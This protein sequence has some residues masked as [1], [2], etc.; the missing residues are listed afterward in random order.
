MKSTLHFF[1]FIF[2][3]LPILNFS[4]VQIGSDINGEAEWDGFGNSI[5][6]SEDGKIMAIGAPENDG[7]GS[8]SGHVRIY[9]NIGGIW[10]QIG[11]DIEGEDEVNYFGESVS[12]SS[13]GNIV[14]IGADAND[15]GGT[16]S[17]HVR[18]YEN[19]EGV[20][21]QI[22]NDIDGEAASD[23]SGTSVSLSSDGNIVAIGAPLNDGN[24]MDS[25]HVRV[26]E[27]VAG[28]W[29]Q[30][31]NDIDGEAAYDYSGASVSLSSNGN[32]VAIGSPHSDGNGWLSGH[33]RVYEYTAGSWVQI[34]EDINGTATLNGFGDSVS[35][36]S[37]GNIVAIGS[38]S[39]NDV[40]DPGYVKVYENITGVWTQIGQD[41]FGEASNDRFGWSVSLSKNGNIVAVGAP[42]N[43][44]NELGPGYARV[45]ENIGGTWT[46][47]GEDIDGL[48]SGEYFG[49]C[50]SLASGG[51]TV[52]IGGYFNNMNGLNTGHVRAYDI[53]GL[54]SIEGFNK[55]NSLSIYPNPVNSQLYIKAEDSISSVQIYNMLGQQ[56]CNIKPNYFMG[57]LDMSNFNSG[58]YLFKV[59][60]GGQTITYKVIKE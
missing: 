53:S 33:V 18:V 52:A 34:G 28:T 10:T 32:I 47:I 13:N 39:T 29:T 38:D 42:Q 14:A 16:R 43:V 49:I 21:T 15:G 2:F 48:V 40:G 41:I 54:L 3:F 30:I 50:V 55:A 20:W 12:L 1:C 23:Y 45:Y 56:M 24:G 37:N 19:I 31:G 59:T 60:I 9:E 35:L 51:S 58:M 8:V 44:I 26:Y 36:S 7:N 22:G 46:Q 5:S 11:E 27:N 6:L 25:G 4:Q 57:E 17:G